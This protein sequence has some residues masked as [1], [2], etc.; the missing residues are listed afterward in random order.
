MKEGPHGRQNRPKRTLKLLGM[1][2]SLRMLGA[3]RQAEEQCMLP[4]QGAADRWGVAQPNGFKR[5]PS[6]LWCS[7]L[8]I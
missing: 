2:G 8:S 3:S 4:A 7:A 1:F 6:C 5:N